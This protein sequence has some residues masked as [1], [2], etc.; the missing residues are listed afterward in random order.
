MKSI[1]KFSLLAVLIILAGCKNDKD[2]VRIGVVA[3]LT[4]PGAEAAEYAIR[5]FNLAIDELNAV[6][7][8]HKYEM[9]YE[10]C[11]SNPNLASTCFKRLEAKGVHYIIALGGQFSLV[12]A[13][14]TD[15]KQMMYFTIG[16]YNE[17][18][19][20]MTDCGFRIFPSATTFG[21]VSARYLLDSLHVSKIATISMN[22]VPCLM[23]ANSLEEYVKSHDG[24]IVFQDKYDIGASDFKNTIAKLAN[25]NVEAVF[26]N[27]IGVSPTAF[28]NQLAQYPQFDNLIV[29]GDVNF[30][31]KSFSDNMK[32][33]GLRVFC[34]DAEMEGGAAQ[35]YL[36]THNSR[37]NTYV[38][39]SYM[40]PYLIDKAITESPK[41]DDFQ[42]QCNVLRGKTITTPAGSIT[43]DE[44]GNADMAM[45][46]F[47]IE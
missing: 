12:V 33:N 18:V 31:L 47:A 41:K 40:L 10:D 14:M 27:G 38:N 13:P 46:V 15:K 29:L 39:C 16:D 25:T 23:S 42:A 5:G 21:E 7:K 3:T 45:K 8:G 37:P 6:D 2:V 28:C 36:N 44:K 24:D 17:T 9:V 32:N 1:L 43:I 11:Q 26:F 22:T 4:G 30:T 35:E 34:A 20:N 19:L